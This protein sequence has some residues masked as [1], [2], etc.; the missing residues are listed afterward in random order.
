MNYDIFLSQHQ[1]FS[2]ALSLTRACPEPVEEER[3]GVWA[4]A[5]GTEVAVEPGAGRGESEVPGT[6]FILL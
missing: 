5:D 3:I 6:E 1:A 4:P 2:D